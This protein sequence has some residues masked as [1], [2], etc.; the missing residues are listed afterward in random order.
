M[1]KNFPKISLTALEVQSTD[2]ISASASLHGCPL[3]NEK[4]GNGTA[5]TT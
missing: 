4:R 2:Y 1:K 5:A 3:Q